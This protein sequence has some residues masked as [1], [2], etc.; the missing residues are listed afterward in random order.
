M[1]RWEQIEADPEYQAEPQDV[2]DEFRRRYFIRNIALD[3]E[4]R[5]DAN[6]PVGTPEHKAAREV[7]ESFLG[8][9]PMPTTEEEEAG[10]AALVKLEMSRRNLDRDWEERYAEQKR[11]APYAPETMAMGESGNPYKL[12]KLGGNPLVGIFQLVTKGVSAGYLAPKEPEQRVSEFEFQAGHPVQAQVAEMAASTFP[13]S[14]AAKAGSALKA[15]T[16]AAI[17]ARAAKAGAAAVRRIPQIGKGP[18]LVSKA[19]GLG[20]EGAIGGTIYETLADYF[21]KGGFDKESPERIATSAVFWA[22]LSML[23]VTPA[24]FKEMSGSARGRRLIAQ[25]MAKGRG[26]E[27]VDVAE[28]WV[29]DVG[30][31]ID[32][33]PP[34]ARVVRKAPF[35]V[36]RP[37]EFEPPPLKGYPR[38]GTPD[39]PFTL[40]RDMPES[41]LS[42]M[43]KEEQ[44]RQALSVG[45]KQKWEIAPGAVRRVPAP[46]ETPV[47]LPT[48]AELAL[49]KTR[50]ARPPSQIPIIG[51]SGAVQRALPPKRGEAILPER[52]PELPP[53]GTS[54]FDIPEPPPPPP[55]AAPT[56]VGAPL[57]PKVKPPT[58]KPVPPKV[59][60]EYPDLAKG[61]GEV[62]PLPIAVK[63]RKGKGQAPYDMPAQTALLKEAGELVE[64]RGLPYTIENIKAAVEELAGKG[65]AKGAPEGKPPAMEGKPPASIGQET[66]EA[67]EGSGPLSWTP[68]ERVQWAR[69]AIERHPAPRYEKEIIQDLESAID[70]VAPID[71]PGKR[72]LRLILAGTAKGF[73]KTSKGIVFHIPTKTAVAGA[74]LFHRLGHYGMV[75]SRRI[76]GQARGRNIRFT[77]TK[78]LWD[79][80][81]PYLKGGE[82]YSAE[83]EYLF[84][85][86]D[87]ELIRLRKKLD[88]GG[89]LSDSEYARLMELSRAYVE[90]IGKE[91][92][93]KMAEWRIQKKLDDIEFNAWKQSNKESLEASKKR[94]AEL[95][96]QRELRRIEHEAYLKEKKETEG[97]DLYSGFDPRLIMRGRGRLAESSEAKFNAADV[98][99]K[100]ARSATRQER[101]DAFKR[102]T[103]DIAAPVKDR[104]RK[105]AGISGEEAAAARDKI[106]GA[107]PRAQMY[108]DAYVK[109]TYKG[110]SRAEEVVLNRY[111]ESLR[112]ITIKGYRPDHLRPQTLDEANA[113]IAGVRQ[114]PELR[115]KLDRAIQTEQTFYL[116]ELER[117]RDEGPGLIRPEDFDA[118]QMRIKDGIYSPSEYIEFIDPPVSYQVGGRTINTTESG[119]PYRLKKGSESVLENDGR[120]LPMEYVMRM[121]N[122][123]NRNKAQDSIFEIAEQQP[124]NGIVSRDPI[125]GADSVKMGVKRKGN[126]Y[127]FYME[128]EA[129]RTWITS[130]P[131]INQTLAKVIGWSTGVIPLKMA[132]T[133]YNA[134]F[135]AIQLVMDSAHLMMSS[136]AYSRHLPKAYAQL[137][138][139]YIQT[140]K[141]AWRRGPKY[142]AYIE[143]DGGLNFLTSQGRLGGGDIL[144]PALRQ[145]D[146]IASYVPNATEAWTRLAHVNRLVKSGVPYNEAVYQ[147][148]MRVDYSQYGAGVKAADVAIP[149]L[150]AAFQS[151]RAP[152]RYAREH[153]GAFT[154]K[155]SQYG[156]ASM[157]LYLANRQNKEAYDSIPAEIKAGYWVITT[158]FY[159]KDKEG[160]RRHVYFTFR[161]DPLQR[162]VGS[163]FEAV[164]ATVVGDE[165]DP[166]QMKRALADLAPVDPTSG[167][168][169]PPA[170][171]ALVGY[172]G[173]VDL[174]RRRP[175]VPG[176][177]G[178]VEL[179]EEYIPGQTHPL[180]VA[181]RHL[182]LSPIRTEYAAKQVLT[183]SNPIGDVVGMGLREILD[184][185]PPDER[186]RA[187]AEIMAQTP[188]LKRIVRETKPDLPYIKLANEV[189]VEV[190]TERWKKN[191]QLDFFAQ[192][193]WNKKD[194][195]LLKKTYSF[196]EKFD[197]D[198]QERLANRFNAQGALIGK[199]D[200]PF[201]M[202]LQ[203]LP[204]EARAR[205]YE[206]KYKS[207]SD[208]EKAAMNERAVSIPGIASDDFVV[209]FQRIRQMRNQR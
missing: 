161:K 176:K 36:E 30:Q 196:L 120:K 109:A 9:V 15:A 182:G 107:T 140:M 97:T 26:K 178:N 205:V 16:D 51:E 100:A 34:E 131:L 192:Q 2:K 208:K 137:S 113:F 89:K 157:L 57:T 197:P 5:A 123:I 126:M 147:A 173:N 127:D 145:L 209:E 22:G 8:K 167:G 184:T 48:A 172:V 188:L 116:K 21:E 171:K 64:S 77:Y 67:V 31:S 83:G 168:L 129:A 32:L 20:V 119:I 134:A 11:T 87:P 148:R 204:P 95:R 59:L 190:N 94:I 50:Q 39:M 106:A 93:K 132:A 163:A 181:M 114:M 144:N 138:V 14:R 99:L 183:Y 164:A 92:D 189:Q 105:V 201:W 12:G 90:T 143:A 185:M 88:S 70:A 38:R 195:E 206:E 61:A 152:L 133:G 101:I 128:P 187:M 110:I 174:Y 111:R 76:P 104:L 13:V 1:T 175:V 135:G 60:A 28:K 115:T 42:L 198:E 55:P 45:L 141:D 121:E 33:G 54:E 200:R 125:W 102:A 124:Q 63:G 186:D 151:M 118:M 17:A 191:R 69:A 165:V 71:M 4:Y 159:H 73:E 155:L 86:F 68:L 193:Y 53:A 142:R 19:A 122:R 56:A 18:G 91:T 160:N 117:A 130:D 139:D 149:Y 40:T 207:L 169:L 108:Y 180:A 112:T 177:I 96:L 43:S 6:A 166:A 146:D 150:N 84:S 199:P 72:D 103:Y 75:S 52:P 23:G 162:V 179:P 27:A 44:M 156:T 158:P 202:R 58:G 37:I 80:P 81:Q 66:G 41:G 46:S 24:A 47:I 194:P 74:Q 98:A 203:D 29:D 3:P 154:Y 10:K 78:S 65:V 49:T 25:I 62:K 85:G 136:G 35:D 7:M 79:E 153:P 82:L 170:F